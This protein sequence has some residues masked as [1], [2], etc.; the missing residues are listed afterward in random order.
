MRV[1]GIGLLR[2]FKNMLRIG[3]VYYFFATT[4]IENYHLRIHMVEFLPSSCQA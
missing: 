1:Y 4:C 3:F 2:T